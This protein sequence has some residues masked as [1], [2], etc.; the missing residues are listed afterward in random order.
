MLK[1]IEKIVKRCEPTLFF[2][3]I[4]FYIFIAKNAKTH[5]QQLIF[6][7]YTDKLYFKC[8]LFS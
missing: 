4:F 5:I 6:S 1:C 8:V 7:L 2:L 3:K